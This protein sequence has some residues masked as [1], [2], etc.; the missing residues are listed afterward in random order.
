MTGYHS[1]PGEDTSVAEVETFVVF[2]GGTAAT[3]GV[4]AARRSATHRSLRAAPP[5]AHSV[6]GAATRYHA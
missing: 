4:A 5:T 3:I 6:S 2:G 1:A